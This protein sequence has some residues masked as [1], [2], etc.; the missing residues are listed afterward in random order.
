MISRQALQ[1]CQ[2]LKIGAMW[3]SVAGGPELLKIRGKTRHFS[4]QVLFYIVFL[5]VSYE[6]ILKIGSM[7]GAGVASI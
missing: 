1:A 5:Q 3:G 4:K 7:W 2:G 6:I